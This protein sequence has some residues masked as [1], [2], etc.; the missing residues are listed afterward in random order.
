L[1]CVVHC[2]AAEVD[3]TLQSQ[4]ILNHVQLKTSEQ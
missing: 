1:L 3:L 4:T 2:L